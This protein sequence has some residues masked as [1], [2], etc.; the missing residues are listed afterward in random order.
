[1]SKKYSERNIIEVKIRKLQT[2]IDSIKL[3]LSWKET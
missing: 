1:V 2:A 3:E